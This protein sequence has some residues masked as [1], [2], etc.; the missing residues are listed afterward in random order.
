MMQ[1]D[2]LAIFAVMND[3][4]MCEQVLESDFSRLGRLSPLQTRELLTMVAQTN[5]RISPRPTHKTTVDFAG[6]RTIFA[7]VPEKFDLAPV[8]NVASG[9][10]LSHLVDD[11]P[12][13][14]A[15]REDVKKGEGSFVFREDGTFIVHDFFVDPDEDPSVAIA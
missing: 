13:D 3:S 6:V 15:L 9:Q 4:K 1:L 5:L 11:M 12:L 2:D 14:P 8:N 10:M 7:E